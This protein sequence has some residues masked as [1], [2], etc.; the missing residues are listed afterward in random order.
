MSA[1][2]LE[3]QLD[4][5]CD[6]ILRTGVNLQPGQPLVIG[7][8][9]EMFLAPMEAREFVH[10]L[11]A[12][13]YVHGASDV[14]VHWFDPVLSRLQKENASAEAM[15]DVA[16]W[17]S[18]RFLQAADRDAAFVMIHVPSPAL[19][20]GIAP[21]RIAPFKKAESEAINPFRQIYSRMQVSWCIIA[22]ATDEWAQQVFPG[23]PAAEAKMKL[24]ELI[25]QAVRADRESPEAE[26]SRHLEQLRERQRYMDGRQF[27]QLRYKGPGTDLTIGLPK[28]HKWISGATTRN[29][30]DIPFVPNL[31]TEEIFTSPDRS[32]TN[33]IVRSTLPLS[34]GG[35]LVRDLAFRFENGKIVEATADMPPSELAAVLGLDMDEGARYLGE[36]ALVP[37][38]S[39]IARMKHIFY[40]TLFDENA[41]CHL[42][43]GNGFPIAVEGGPGL[44]KA[45]LSELGINASTT[46]VDF[47]IGSDEL[48]IDG[49]TE[50]GEVVPLF[51]QG[52]WVV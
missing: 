46:H 30:K 3:D 15:T 49:V 35:R 9:P 36:V 16:P 5:Y 12:R 43:F 41:S 20:A 22:V 47:M 26:W 28:G 51:R 33:G 37:Q 13:A 1:F 38:A 45:V 14:D 17:K 19:Y 11:A 6:V 29:A 23:E 42:A 21:D 52:N 50:S 24:W 2:D 48:D 44:D 4:R 10:R 27:A 7:A 25:L 40:N 34:W 18:D 8:G 32:K 39:P 31:P